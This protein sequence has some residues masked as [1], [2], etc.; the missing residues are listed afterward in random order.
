MP[1]TRS[2]QAHLNQV[3]RNTSPTWECETGSLP[4]DTE[5]STSPSPS[6]S[7]SHSSIATTSPS[8]PSD[9]H[10][11]TAPL[12]NSKYVRNA[13]KPKWSA[14]QDRFLVQEVFACR[15]FLASHRDA[16]SAWEELAKKIL[17]TSKTQ[18]TAIDRTGAACR[19]QFKRLVKAHKSNETRSLQ[20]TGTNEQID[21]HVQT[22]T[23][24]VA[25][26]DGHEA[27]KE[28]FLATSKKQQALQQ[29][30]A[31]EMRD[32]AMKGCV[33]RTALSD[34]TQ[35]E[36]A[37]VH[38]KQGQRKRKTMSAVSDTDKENAG[39][40]V[41]K[42]P[43]HETALEKVLKHR[44]QNEQRQL[45]EARAEDER[46][47]QELKEGLNSMANNISKLVDAIESQ[48]A[49]D[50]QQTELMKMVATLLEKMSE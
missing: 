48:S 29:K 30:A 16:A 31:L 45:E 36:G 1:T 41:R 9:S 44:E 20:D 24:L 7:P 46:R 15:P 3:T 47:H 19:T 5:K 22:M 49:R 8:P 40:S 35:M 37:T 13:K 50:A 12:S 10:Q 32:A 23:D 28:E 17:E 39:P 38:E 14:W 43:R 18:G 21:E 6:P 4:Q 25:L 27:S 34:V 42:R 11:V 33:P 26:V 2:Q